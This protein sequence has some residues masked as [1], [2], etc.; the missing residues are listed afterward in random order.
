MSLIGYYNKAVVVHGNNGE[1]FV[2]IV[3]D[4]IYPEDNESGVESIII[5]TNRG[6]YEIVS[7]DIYEI[8]IL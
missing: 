4:Y 7:E 8:E 2:G 6:Y 1:R 3:D 5:K